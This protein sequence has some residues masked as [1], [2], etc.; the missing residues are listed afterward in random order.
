MCDALLGAWR[1][2]WLHADWRAAL[3][4]QLS[5][6]QIWLILPSDADDTFVARATQF[7]SRR[8]RFVRTFIWP[9][10]DSEIIGMAMAGV[11]AIC[12]AVIL[13]LV[14]TI[15]TALAMALALIEGQLG[16]ERRTG[17]RAIFEIAFPWS[18]ATTAL[19]SISP[20]ACVFILLFTLIYYMLLSMV[21]MR[22]ERWGM[23][24]HLAQL[25]VVLLLVASN[26]PL[27]AGVV[28]LGLLAQFLWQSRYQ[29]DRDGR[30]FAQHVQSYVLVGMFVTG[31]SLW[32]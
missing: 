13:G 9:L 2:L 12:I 10:I 23:V 8:I 26:A 25:A 15:L 28:A 1:A 29:T 19:G 27:G 30:A 31:L 11:L 32:L 22:R 24:S 21:A 17:L 6:A 3:P 14:P 18:I 5:K 16:V 7:L 20:L 4:Q